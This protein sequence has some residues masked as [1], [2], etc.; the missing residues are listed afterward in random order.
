MKTYEIAVIL[1]INAESYDEALDEVKD[2]VDCVDTDLVNGEYSHLIRH[3]LNATI[4]V[5]KDYETDNDG[6]RV[7][8]LPKEE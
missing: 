6:Q 7:L 8:Y 5:V 2:L 3:W 4:N 1:S